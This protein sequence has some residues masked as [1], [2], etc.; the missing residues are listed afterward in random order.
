M[1]DDDCVIVCFFDVNVNMTMSP[2]AASSDAG[3]QIRPGMPPTVTCLIEHVSGL[4][5]AKALY[6]LVN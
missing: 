4:E 3:L 2:T 6:L 1:V 5:R